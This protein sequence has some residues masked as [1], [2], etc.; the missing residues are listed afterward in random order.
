MEYN[1]N[2]ALVDGYHRMNNVQT[3]TI[4]AGVE[5]HHTTIDDDCENVDASEN[6]TLADLQRVGI[7]WI[8]TVSMPSFDRLHAI[9][10]LAKQQFVV[11]VYLSIVPLLSSHTSLFQFA[12]YYRS[13]RVSHP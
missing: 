6:R 11:T 12:F 2:R 13:H 8:Q 7:G 3:T 1:A 5:Y 10:K 9:F 4:C